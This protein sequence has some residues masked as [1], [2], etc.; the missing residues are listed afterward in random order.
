MLVDIIRSCVKEDEREVTELAKED[1][2][3]NAAEALW[4]RIAGHGCTVT[5]G[6][7]CTLSADGGGAGWIKQLGWRLMFGGR[8]LDEA[9]PALPL[10]RLWT[11]GLKG[12]KGGFG[13]MLRA[14]AKQAGNKATRDFGACRDLQGRRL[15]HVNDEASHICRCPGNFKFFAAR[16]QM[17]ADAALRM[18]RL[19]KWQEEREKREKR[20]GTEEEEDEAPEQTPS[21]IE[22][23]H[24]GVPSWA[25]GLNKQGKQAQSYLKPRRK[26]RV[27]K[28]W[29]EARAQR[30]APDGAPAWWGC[31]RGRGCDFAHGDDELKGEAAKEVKKR[32]ALA[33]KEE[34][35]KELDRYLAA[36]MEQDL[37]HDM[38][39]A[40]QQ[41]LVAAQ[42]AKKQKTA[43]KGAATP[44]MLRREPR[45]L[46]P[47]PAQAAEA[48]ALLP[49]AAAPAAQ[50]PE[51]KAGDAVDL[52]AATEC[53][54]LGTLAG[55]L[56]M[57]ETGQVSGASEFASAFVR[58]VSGASE[59]ASAF[60]R[61]V[62]LR[63]GRWYYEVSLASD[64]LVQ[65]GWAD[66]LFKGDSFEGN[67]IGDDPHLCPVTLLR[68]MGDSF[69]GNGIGDDTHSWAYDG[70]RQK[71]WNGE[72]D[73]ASAPDYGTAWKVGDVVGCLLDADAGTLSFTH[74]GQDLGVAFGELPRYADRTGGSGNPGSANPGNPAKRRK[75]V[76]AGYFPAFSLEFGEQV[77]VNAGAIPF[78]HPPPEGY[79][80]V[81]DAMAADAQPSSSADAAAEAAPA[82]VLQDGTNMPAAKNRAPAAAAAAES[83]AAAR[84]AAAAAA[85]SAEAA[86][87]APAP[88]PAAAVATLRVPPPGP[89]DL[90]LYETASELH[91]FGLDRLREE[92][93][94]GLK[95]E[96][97]SRGVKL[98][99]E[100]M[101]RGVKC[102]GTLHD[103]AARL[104][105]LKGLARADYPPSLL[106]AAPKPRKKA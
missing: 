91:M 92:H 105:E 4:S 3:R 93:K 36:S 74:N 83:A 29:L 7:E 79:C 43:L 95:E 17:D 81:C 104:L 86:A 75:I 52:A 70:L 56:R 45:A 90:S 16:V 15:R 6:N 14:A 65:L 27:C 18:I 71:R 73:E 44:T 25:E 21:G 57:D 33:T 10:V 102:G 77:V 66:H 76:D 8:F 99:E 39:D 26:T 23:W 47:L 63:T 12:G 31:P 13:A 97:M 30:P 69:E 49:L 101:S 1:D 55:E 82:H 67:G 61:G 42:Q 50:A 11:G 5:G 9:E 78:R 53:S 106:A 28:Q 59:F 37:G 40:V 88:A 98:K 84:A 68:A 19:R 100:L 54:W 24:L 62:R 22:N 60:V 32:K 51:G 41:G 35:A 38:A 72:E 58:G 87:A 20:K 89:I 85:A 46:P 96:L 103:R 64:G 80:A 2:L 34:A 94:A 48:R